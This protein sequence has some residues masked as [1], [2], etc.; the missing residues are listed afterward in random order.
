MRL[1]SVLSILGITIVNM[2]IAI[3]IAIH[4]HFLIGLVSLFVLTS[5]YL[6]IISLVVSRTTNQQDVP[7]TV[8]EDDL[9][10]D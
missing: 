9:S 5:I 3:V 8:D 7:V 10:L 1:W 6:L 2:V 4:S